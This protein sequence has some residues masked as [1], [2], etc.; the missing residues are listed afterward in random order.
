MIQS[1]VLPYNTAIIFLFETFLD[2]SIEARDRNI[3]ISGCFSACFIKTTY[4]ILDGW[5]IVTEIQLGEKSIFFTCNYRSPS[6]TSDEFENYC[7]NFQFTLS[8]I[9]DTSPFF[10]IV[11]GDF[12]VRCRNLLAVVVNSNTGKELDFLTSTAG[13][14]QDKL[15]HLFSCIS[16]Y[17][18]LILCNKPEIVNT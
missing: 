13:Y 6:H 12:N 1:Y 8:N 17:I 9:D 10:S 7:Q 14:T 4:L 3:H 11:F 16:S 5:S 15:T 2:S 18:N